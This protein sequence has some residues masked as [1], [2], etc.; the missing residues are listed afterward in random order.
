MRRAT[1]AVGSSSY[2]RQ[3][4]RRQRASGT[5]SQEQSGL[6]YP[7]VLLDRLGQAASSGAA[8]HPQ[9]PNTHLTSLQRICCP[10]ARSSAAMQPVGQVLPPK[11]PVQ[12]SSQLTEPSLPSFRMFGPSGGSWDA[13][14]GISASASAGRKM[15]AQPTQ[16]RVPGRHPSLPQQP[17]PASGPRAHC[18]SGS[19]EEGEQH[20]I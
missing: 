7:H 3:L 17:H 14:K 10:E 1:R 20:S 11:R 15:L 16:S 18:V 4:A 12:Y 13:A 8:A 19:R 5:A 6:A 2:W 9:P